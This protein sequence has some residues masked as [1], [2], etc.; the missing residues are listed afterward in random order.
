MLSHSAFFCYVT[1]RKRDPG[2]GNGSHNEKPLLLQTATTYTVRQ[3]LETC[4]KTLSVLAT[5][6]PAFDSPWIKKNLFL[7]KM[8]KNYRRKWI[9][10]SPTQKQKTWIL[11]N[12]CTKKV[13]HHKKQDS[14]SGPYCI[15]VGWPYIFW[16]PYWEASPPTDCGEHIDYNSLKALLFMLVLVWIPCLSSYRLL[17]LLMK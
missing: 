4:S 7:S 2:G 15:Q 1:V 6:R 3:K 9:P 17:P 16:P 5:P 8:K 12:N 11:F 14:G 10:I 13:R